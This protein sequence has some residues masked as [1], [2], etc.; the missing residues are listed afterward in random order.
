MS[1]QELILQSLREVERRN[2]RNRLLKDSSR[3]LAWFLV[4]PLAFRLAALFFPLP[5]R[6]VAVGTGV[7]LILA[8]VYTAKRMRRQDSLA[9]TAAQVDRRLELHDEIR[10]AYWFINSARQSEWIDLQIRRAA[11]TMRALDLDRFYP[12][13][14]PNTIYVPACMLLLFV[15]AGLIAPGRATDGGVNV[16]RKLASNLGEIGNQLLPSDQTARPPVRV[17]I[18]SSEQLGD[19]AQQTR[20]GAG[21]QS[22]LPDTLPGTMNLPQGNEPT[23]L[24]PS[25]NGSLNPPRV[26]PP[27]SLK[28]QLEKEKLAGQ[29]EERK[30]QDNQE[31]SK[32]ERSKIDYHDVP[33]DLRLAQQDLLNHDWTPTRYRPLIKNYFEAIRPTE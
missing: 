1:D 9:E 26:G 24:D 20:P 25:G 13:V 31:S 27:T 28:V 17:I 4:F 18:P 8:A 15:A 3:S 32:H 14:V 2:R 22:P 16:L 5:S 30:R 7:A 33:S 11:G 12:R 29:Q 10:T 23:G 21:W 19:A 6:A